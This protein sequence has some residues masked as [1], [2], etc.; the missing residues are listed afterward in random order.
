M[1][2]AIDSI[3]KTNDR[4]YHHH[5]G[6]GIIKEIHY[7]VNKRILIEFDDTPNL[8]REMFNEKPVLSFTEYKLVGFS[9]ERPE[10]LPKKGQIVWVRGKFRSEWTIGHFIEKI[11]GYYFV[12][13]YPNL[14]DWNY[15]GIEIRT[16]NPY[17]NEQ[18]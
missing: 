17:E 4:V 2:I 13:V 11:E 9:Q 3:F 14:K 5:Y 10:E 6:W 12:S 16:T 18:N 7:G 15:K 8:V 1:R